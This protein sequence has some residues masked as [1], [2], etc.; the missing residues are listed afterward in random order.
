M[1]TTTANYHNWE[2][3]TTEQLW[4]FFNRTESKCD[5]VYNETWPNP[6]FK[7]INRLEDLQFEILAVLSERGA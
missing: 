5:Q 7:T 4:E 1:K 2:P 6:D 3:F